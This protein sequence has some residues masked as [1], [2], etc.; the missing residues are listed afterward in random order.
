MT[1]EVKDINNK[2]VVL[3]DFDS[4]GE[5]GQFYITWLIVDHIEK[6]E[7]TQQNPLEAAV[8]NDTNLNP[9]PSERV[10]KT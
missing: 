5:Q 4:S 7:F 3:K 9:N 10:P 1:L 2:T 8:I 6:A